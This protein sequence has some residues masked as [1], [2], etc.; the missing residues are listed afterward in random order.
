MDPVPPTDVLHRNARRVCDLSV[1]IQTP[2]IEF[3][4]NFVRSEVAQK[5]CCLNAN[6]VSDLEFSISY[7][8][9]RF[10]ADIEPFTF[11]SCQPGSEVSGTLSST[12][13]QLLALFMCPC[14][15]I[16]GIVLDHPL[17]IERIR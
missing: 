12:R 3:H 14:V 1:S 6:C 11:D 8:V 2:D 17:R 13:Q 15:K 10:H 4:G 5:Y 7:R 16:R 9:D